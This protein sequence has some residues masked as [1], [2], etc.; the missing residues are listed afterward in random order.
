VYAPAGADLARHLVATAR[1]VELDPLRSGRG[2]AEDARAVPQWLLDQSDAWAVVPL[3]HLDTLVGVVVLARPAVDRALDW[4]DFDLLRVAG[5]QVASHLAEARAR[6]ALAEGQRF[7]EF[8]RRFAFIVHDIKNLVSGLTLVAH[9]AERHAD[10][11]EF[12]ADMVATLQDSAAKLNALLAR[13]SQHNHVRYDPPAP[14]AIAVVAARIA[15]ARRSARPVIIIGDTGVFALA[16]PA[17][18]ELLLS[19][20]VQNAIEASAASDPVAISI[21]DRGDSVAVSVIDR[22]CGMSPAFIRDE[23]FR[24]FASSKPNGFGIGAYEAR[25]LAEG[26]GAR[27][28][29]E[30]RE[31]EGSTFRVILPPA[32]AL[33]RAA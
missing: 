8:N 18:L 19:H 1:I 32:L 24:P 16:D 17:R 23:L 30:S 6:D 11:P 25:Q 10:N 14:T 29:V 3:L 15:A 20:L 31:G 28:E 13:L 22:G 26:I 5:R 2:D 27:I 9:N 33:E 12:R 4:E 21:E 7:D